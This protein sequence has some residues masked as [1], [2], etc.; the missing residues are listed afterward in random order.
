MVAQCTIGGVGA[1]H[2]HNEGCGDEAV[3]EGHS[4][5]NDAPHGTS[6]TPSA[7]PFHDSEV[8][9]IE[10]IIG[11]QFTMRLTCN[12]P[13]DAELCATCPVASG[14]LKH[15]LSGQ[16]TWAIPPK[17][18]SQFWIRHYK[19]C[20]DSDPCNTS[21]AF[22]VAKDT[23]ATAAFTGMQLI[24]EYNIDSGE[25]AGTWQVWYDPPAQPRLSTVTAANAL[26]FKCKI[27]HRKGTALV[28][29]GA[30][31]TVASASAVQGTALT[32]S[33]LG[34]HIEIADG[35]TASLLGQAQLPI[36]VQK[37]MGIVRTH[38]LSSLPQGIDIILG[39]D[40]LTANGA[41]LDIPG[42]RCTLTTVAHGARTKQYDLLAD[43]SSQ[44][45][46]NPHSDTG[47]ATMRLVCAA[48]AQ[49]TTPQLM[50]A[51]AARRAVKKGHRCM[52]VLVQPDYKAAMEEAAKQY[53]NGT[54]CVTTEPSQ[55]EGLM[56]PNTVTSILAEYSDVFEP[57]SG[58]PPDRGIGH[59]IPL[60]P[61]AQPSFQRMY[62]LSPAELEEVKKQ[63]TDLLEK[64]LIEPSTSPWGAPIL[65]ATKADGSL[66]MCI[67]YRQLNKHTVKNR[68]PLPNP[69]DL[70]DA[71][72]GATIFSS[73]DLQ[74]GYHQIAITENDRP[75]TAFRT[76]LGHF[77]FKVLPFGICNAPATFQA[78]MNAILQPFLGKSVLAY[79]DDIIVFS[80]TAEEHEQHLRAVLDTLRKSNLK[81]KLSKCDFNKPELKFLGHIVGRDGLKVD[82]SKVAVVRNWPTP[83]DVSSLRSFL[84]LANYFRRFI[85]GYSSLVAPLTRLTGHTAEWEWGTAQQ[86][87]F[88]GVKHALT[89]APVLV[90]P[91]PNK[92][93]EVIS[94]ASLHGTGG[95]LLQDGR[96]VAYT[97]AK[98]TPAERNY[99]TKE[100]ELLGVYLALKEWRCYLEGA[101]EDVTLVTDHNPNTYLAEQASLSNL[102]R[103]QVRWMEF[104]SR[105]H[106]KWEYR[107]GRINV[108]DP[109]SRVHAQLFALRAALQSDL[110]TSIIH[111]YT[112]DPWFQ[113]HRALHKHGVTCDS[114]GYYRREG[115]VVVPGQHDLRSR[116]IMDAHDT[117]LAGHRGIERTLELLKRN[118]WW[119]GMRSQVEQHVR[120]CLLCQRNKAPTQA[121]GGLL[122]PLPVP[123]KPWESVTVDFVTHLPLTANGYNAI[124]VF[125][126]RLT[127][128]VRVAPTTDACTAEELAQ[129]FIDNVVRNHGFPEDMTS[130]RGPQF[131]S[132]FWA[133]VLRLAQCNQKLS[134]AFHPQTDGQTERMNR[135]LQE[136]LR[137]YVNP[138]L[139]D[140]DTKLSLV[141][142]AINNTYNETIK[143]TP[144]QLN[145]GRDPHLPHLTGL[146][147]K[148]PSAVHFCNELRDRLEHAKAA[149]AAAQERYKHYADATRREATYK[150]GQLVLLSTKNIRFNH[151]GSGKLLPR[152]IGP[153][154]IAKRINEVAFR[155]TL[156]AHYRIHDVF[157]VSLLK[158]YTGKEQDD[159]RPGPINFLDGEPHWSVSHVISHR[160]VKRGKRMIREYLCAWD[161]YGPEHNSWEPATAIPEATVDAYLAECEIRA[162]RR[163][164]D[165]GTKKKRPPKSLACE[166]CH[167]T[168]GDA[169]MLLCDQCDT[170]WHT[171]CL[172]PPLRRPPPGQWFCPRCKP[173]RQRR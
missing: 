60:L 149:M 137:N 66:R 160:D 115:K 136:V 7:V 107:P 143:A 111:G 112:M 100:Q 29:T 158:P 6:A 43:T 22:L 80:K 19:R 8:Q 17:Q 164:Q 150:E 61:D 135:V 33:S 130:D 50:S 20:K 35:K 127:K 81:A 27:G 88:D 148:V 44:E 52:L 95:V 110:P 106:Y 77:Q 32:P 118:F 76:P 75:L 12:E 21:A 14:F 173:K 23:T 65:F 128:M 39:M 42:R 82:E 155:L 126:D 117:P 48:L 165:K 140:W 68:A 2:K 85:Q 99:T 70:F 157:H 38:V 161:G 57:I 123:S 86:D 3:A 10:G 46:D 56:S 152:Y 145:H 4:P 25:R 84:G 51:S 119:P 79:M 90:L 113:N 41:V 83:T 171:A 13:T 36:T 40:W 1:A 102:S 172:D 120:S 166:I 134:S 122:Q 69:I 167:R 37:Y 63:V 129:L 34:S 9:A 108:A 97:S 94:D 28:D 11:R 73:I 87:A 109:I 74:S 5:A 124:V 98:F 59:T 144:F 30:T 53:A 142:F 64:G 89:N 138:A 125:V 101:R 91:D 67:D 62:R 131:N 92:A 114:D 168:D 163:P 141:E 24:R 71:M 169:T 153:F 154:R 78:T 45:Q 55:A 18:L 72:Q 121:P 16:H 93:Y 15:N 133:E 132:N 116:L 159:I 58:P 156:P 103:R 139:D 104:F 54:V 170:G 31:H 26:T 146:R 49:H 151:P 105:F 47:I 147:S 162:A 96:P